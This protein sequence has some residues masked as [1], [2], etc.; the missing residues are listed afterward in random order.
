MV[1]FEGYYH[2]LWDR[3]IAADLES[4]KLDD[5]LGEVDAEIKSGLAKPL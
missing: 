2:R 3:Q 1:W 4:G 5:I